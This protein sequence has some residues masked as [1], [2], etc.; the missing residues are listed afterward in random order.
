M[1]EVQVGHVYR[2]GREAK[3]IRY[4]RVIKVSG[5]SGQEIVSMK[6]AERLG[7]TI[8][9]KHYKGAQTSHML[10]RNFKKRFHLTEFEM[11]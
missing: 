1:K 3:P 9:C 4:V 7:E 10:L 5:A 8:T 11:V 2:E 6:G